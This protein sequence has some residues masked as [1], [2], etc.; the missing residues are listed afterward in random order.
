M[1]A[2]GFRV[3]SGGT[4]TH[5]MLVDVFSKGVRGREAE[6][7]RSTGP[8]SRSTRTPFRSTSIRR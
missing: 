4:D 2:E 7:T 1:Q 6:A 8:A 3:I 5:L